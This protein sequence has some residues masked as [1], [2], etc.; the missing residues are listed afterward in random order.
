MEHKISEKVEKILKL[1]RDSRKKHGLSH[2]NMAHELDISVS[3]YNKLERS[4]TVLSLD[5]LFKIAEILK[6]P[7]S[8]VFEIKTGDTLHQ[9]LN[10]NSIG[11]VDNL[12][13]E[14]KEKSQQIIKLYEMHITELNDRLREKDDI[15]LHYKNI[16]NKNM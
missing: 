12:Q 11:K 2:E 3:A 4:E 9:N 1:I 10:D 16:V 6:M 14:N 15:I 7:L 13:Q 5:R 8:E